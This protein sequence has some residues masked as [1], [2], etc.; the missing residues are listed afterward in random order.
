MPSQTAKPATQ[1]PYHNSSHAKFLPAQLAG[2]TEKR[3]KAPRVAGK[4]GLR[5]EDLGLQCLLLVFRK[6]PFRYGR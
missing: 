3:M 4:L 5:I 6:P 1:P 2:L